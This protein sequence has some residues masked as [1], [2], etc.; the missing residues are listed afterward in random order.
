MFFSL[1]LIALVFTF[2]N[3]FSFDLLIPS[4]GNHYQFIIL[5]PLFSF[6]LI[7]TLL[8]LQFISTKFLKI[9]NILKI[10]LFL[11]LNAC[12]H[13]WGTLYLFLYKNG[14]KS[15]EYTFWDWVVLGDLKITLGFFYDAVVGIMLVVILTVSSFVHWYASSYMEMDP[16]RPRFLCYLSLFTFFMLILVTAPNLIQ[17]F[18]GWEGV[19]ICSYLLINFWFTRI[20]ANKAAL[21]AVMVNRVGDTALALG[22]FLIFQNYGTVHI[23]TLSTMLLNLDSVLFDVNTIAFFLFI[24][25][26]GKSAQI[27]LH[28]W[29]PDAMEGPTP[30]SALLHAATMVT[31]G[32]F[33]LIRCSFVFQE[34]ALILPIITIVGAMTT[35]FAATT[36]IAQ[37]DIKRVIAYSTCSQLGYM[38]MACGVSNFN[39]ALFHLY[40]HAFF[41]ALLFL[42]AGSIIHALN[43]EQDMRKMGGLV[44]I[45]PFTY[46]MMAIG[47]LALMGF[48][49]LSG[50]YSKE[51]ILEVCFSKY[52]ITSHFAFWLGSLAASCTAY[53]SMRALIIIFLGEVN[54]NKAIVMRAHESPVFMIIPMSVLCIMSIVTGYLSKDIF[55]GL[56]TPFWGN[57]MNFYPADHKAA[58][59]AEMLP[60][61]FKVIPLVF[62]IFGSLISI[63][64]YN[65]LLANQNVYKNNLLYNFCNR[66]WFF[67]AFYNQVITQGFFQFGYSVSYSTLDRGFFEAIGSLGLVKNISIITLIIKKMQSGSPSVYFLFFI[68]GFCSLTVFLVVLFYGLNPLLLLLILSGDFLIKL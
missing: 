42:S 66:K 33:L 47:S 56:G 68:S 12:Y 40:N 36:A 21:K 60:F 62:S 38:V 67:D 35:I 30:V 49:Y 2:L 13:A 65:Y 61:I 55:I 1:T 46:A 27:G 51:F 45:L 14:E 52:T 50:Y 48:P 34:A 26:V 31:A 19:G 41:K 63:Y 25:A 3:I 15:F 29:L 22:I 5:Y 11:N 28:T 6:L 10:I 39:G 32:V 16:N 43:N 18:V 23:K 4:F 9:E 24:G 57:S 64:M 53:Y 8:N 37:N 44:N 58:V 17:L 59:N 20:Q 54:A 7:A